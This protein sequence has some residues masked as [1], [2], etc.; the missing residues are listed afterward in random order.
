MSS[1]SRVDITQA[2]LVEGSIRHPD[3]ASL[4]LAL[5]DE[6][7]NP[8]TLPKAGGGATTLMELTDVTGDPGL[9]KAPVA[10]H[11]GDFPLTE[12]ATQAYVDSVVNDALGRWATLGQKLSFVSDISS[13]WEVSNPS[14]VLTPDGLS[15]GPYGDG[16]AAGGSIR[17]HGLDG[18]PF[19]SVKNLAYNMRFTNDHDTADATPYLR[20]YTQDSDGG[21]HDSICT[22]NGDIFGDQMANGRSIS[23][24][25]FQEYVATAG[26]W[27]YDS[28]DGSNSE[29]ARGVPLSTILDKYG[30][31]VITKIA[32]TL[33]WTSGVNLAGLLRWMQINGNRYTFGS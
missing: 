12:V 4:R 11:T 31:Q 5:F 32:I 19:S 15:F 25:P 23:A 24:G 17:F 21:D 9:G 27:R 30:D 33:G 22:G 26:S 13:P 10:D 28:D 8:L 6:Q 14:V 3:Q 18:E 1:R 29:F 2:I 20:V 7:G 16:S